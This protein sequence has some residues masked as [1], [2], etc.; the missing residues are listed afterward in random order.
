MKLLPAFYTP[1][2][3]AIFQPWTLGAINITELHC[4]PN[5]LPISIL[6][7]PVISFLFEASIDY[8][9]EKYI[10]WDVVNGFTGY[11]NPFLPPKQL[12]GA[13]PEHLKTL[14]I[15]YEGD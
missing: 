12:I 1:I 6:N 5:I 13:I 11:C 10:R 3:G 7:T 15:D 14:R 9:P 2:D 4:S 8:A